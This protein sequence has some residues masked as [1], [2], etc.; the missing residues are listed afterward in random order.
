MLNVNQVLSVCGRIISYD[1]DFNTAWFVEHTESQ[2]YLMCWANS[3]SNLVC[4]VNTSITAA[5]G[6][7]NKVE[8]AAFHLLLCK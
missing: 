1:Y 3:L 6:Q 8:S 4:E 5:S 2:I 7:C